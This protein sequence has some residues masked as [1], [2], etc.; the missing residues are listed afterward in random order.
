MAA[1]KE[2]LWQMDP[3]T[4]GKHSVLRAYLHAWLPILGSWSKRILFIDGFAGPGE[5]VGG[6]EG[7]PLIALRA[8]ADHSAKQVI[9]GEVGFIF[10]ENRADRAEHLDELIKAWQ[11]KIPKRCWTRVINGKFDD[12]L[13][14]LLN[15]LDRQKARLAPTFLMIDPFGVSGTPM[16][17]VAR[18]LK[19][20]QCEVYVSLM[21]E[22][23]NRHCTAPEFE[24]PLDAL[25]GSPQW[26]DCAAT[27]ESGARR[28][29]FYKLYEKQLRA[30]GARYV[31]HFD[32]YEG[33]RLIYSIF[34]ATQ[35]HLGCDRMKAAIWKVAPTGKFEFRGTRSRQLTLSL[36]NPDYGPLKQ[37]LRDKFTGKG[38]MPIE[39]V[40]EFVR[41]DQT[42]YHSGQ[43]KRNALVPLEHEGVVEVEE[44]TRKRKGTFPPGCVVRFNDVFG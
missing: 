30:S 12:T 29:C 43:L 22:S 40:T 26:R 15:D 32:L 6:E 13:G 23:I 1:P 2:I 10:I 38:W 24:S 7:S 14:D 44:R 39:Q 34:F 36:D 42:D 28:D 25:F 41:S 21:Y 17:V 9:T 35:H 19:N 31:V 4:A 27:E 16:S 37:A 5:Y 11:G 3:H 8:F 33:N 18:V 20:P